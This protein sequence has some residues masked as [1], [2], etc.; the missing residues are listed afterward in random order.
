MDIIM[1][2]RIEN[3]S[4]DCIL[5]QDGSLAAGEAAER[6]SPLGGNIILIGTGNAEAEEY[7]EHLSAGLKRALDLAKAKG[8]GRLSVEEDS[9]VSNPA[10][11]GYVENILVD[12]LVGYSCSSP[13]C[14][15]KIYLVSAL[16]R[17]SEEILQKSEEALRA[18]AKE[19]KKLS[20]GDYGDPLKKQFEQQYPTDTKYSSFREYFLKLIDEKHFRKYSEVYKRA[21]VSKS[22]FSKILNFSLDY[23]PSKSTV[24]AFTIGLGLDLREAQKFYHS[25]GYHLG[26]ADIS[27]RIIRFFIE[28]GIYDIGEVNCCM[29]YYGLPPL[30]EHPRDDSVR[31]IR[32]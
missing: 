15:L 20:F 29:V 7:E 4:I 23:K 28:Q 30:G 5:R 10:Y 21:G 17:G 25:A 13:R 14:G 12:A 19:V 3:D 8:Y 6:V 31:I 2:S 22:T 27:D 11:A 9:F 26:V 32:K 16:V 18:P 1:Q 24:A